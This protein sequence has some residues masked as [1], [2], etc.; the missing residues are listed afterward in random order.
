RLVSDAEKAA[1]ARRILDGVEPDVRRRLAALG[2]AGAVVDA[3]LRAHA[4]YGGVIIRS[5]YAE[6]ALEAAVGRGVRQYVIIGAG[7]DSFIVRQ[8]PFA[9]GIQIFEIDHP[10]TQAMKRRRLEERAV[11]IPANVHLVAADLGRESL[12]SVLARSPFSGAVPAFFS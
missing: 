3:T 8:P 4:T 11:E 5:R 2:S 10:A 7:F 9:R 1:L 6:D 12:S